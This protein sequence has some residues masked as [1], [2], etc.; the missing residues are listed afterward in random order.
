MTDLEGKDGNEYIELQTR[1]AVALI[2][3][4]KMYQHWTEDGRPHGYESFIIK[5]SE[6]LLE[7]IINGGKA[8]E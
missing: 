2:G 6:L 8:G 3:S 4:D 1:L 7:G 5:S